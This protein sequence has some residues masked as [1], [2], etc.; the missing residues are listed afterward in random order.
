V[1]EDS[2]NSLDKKTKIWIALMHL[3]VKAGCHQR[4]DRSFFFRGYQFPVC[5]R[6]TGLFIGYLLGFIF[7]WFLLP[8]KLLPLGICTFV[9]VT[10]LGIDGV[11]QLKNICISNNPR[12]I[13]TGLF[14][15]FF[16]VC[17]AIK[18]IF[19]VISLIWAR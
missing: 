16:L 2:N 6:C 10:A 1:E 14:C 12:R 18:V 15:G 4:H 5:A 8:I 17:F 19:V 11:L 13:I 3:G 7:C 9:S